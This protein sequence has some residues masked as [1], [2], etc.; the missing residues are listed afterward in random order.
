MART[1]DRRPGKLLEEEI[2]LDD[3]TGEGDPIDERAI[4][5]LNGEFRMRDSLGVFNPRGGGG[6]GDGITEA[7]H[8]GLDTLAH[9]LTE[10]SFDVATYS[11]NRV[12]NI[13]TYTDNSESVKVRERVYVYSGIRVTQV[14]TIQY[15]GAGVELYRIRE[16]ISYVN[17]S[18]NRV[19]S[20][21]R[22]R[23]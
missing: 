13:T 22:V 7:E 23:I 3:R 21:T 15:D 12:T 2:L 14:D 9:G 16:T 10:D 4:R 20:I 6:T 11:G 1:P 8:E 5:Y 19:A 18:G 17:P